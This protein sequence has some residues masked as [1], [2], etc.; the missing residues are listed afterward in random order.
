MAEIISEF[1]KFVDG[2]LQVT[3]PGGRIYQLHAGVFRRSSKLFSTLL[4]EDLGAV[5][6]TKAKKEGVM[7]RYRIDLVDIDSDNPHFVSRVRIPPQLS[8][9]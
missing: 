3:L 8:A 6:S 4:A 9:L 7:I 1:P 5:L 2:D